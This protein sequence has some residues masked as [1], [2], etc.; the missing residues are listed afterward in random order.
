MRNIGRDR[1]E[2]HMNNLFMEVKEIKYIERYLTNLYNT[3]NP[4]RSIRL[5]FQ[6]VLFLMFKNEN[7]SVKNQSLS[8]CIGDIAWESH[9]P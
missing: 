7:P 6:L 8:T 1:I 4:Y 2:I 3:L 9:F 5:Y